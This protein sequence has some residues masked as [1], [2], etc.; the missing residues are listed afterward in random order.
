MTQ[1][2]SV[3]QL[4]FAYERE[5]ILD[6]NEFE[7]SSNSVTAITGA[8]GSGKTTLLN[9]FAL[10]RLPTSGSL[11]FR[12]QVVTKQ[13]LTA[14]RQDIGYVQQKPY[15]L[16]RSVYENVELGLKFRGI[17]ASE[18]AQTV[19]AIL[20]KTD[21]MQLAD[22]HA[23]TL[24]GGESQKV[25][26]ARALV[27]QPS[28]LIL[29][30][31]FS[32]LDRRAVQF[33]EKFIHSL[34]HSIGVTIIFSSHDPIAAQLLSDNVY[35]VVHGRLI[36]S[37]MTNL[38]FGHVDANNRLFKTEKIQIHIPEN[39]GVGSHLTIDP[40][41]LVL[42]RNKLDSSM[43]NQFQGSVIAV[44]QQRSQIRLT[45]NAGE[46]FD[47]LITADAMQDMDIRFGDPVWISFKSSAVRV[48]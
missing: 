13:N 11:S 20:Q 34:R 46:K 47:V 14:L 23:H 17:P 42:S 40:N 21:I 48:F 6:V 18:R 35:S 44:N 12:S 30:E 43:R 36:A 25:A 45:I 41:H 8:N 37:T 33:F 5:N 19:R 7:I 24:S 2:Y 28:V 1:L 3:K 4:S 15:L 10:L 39:A 29:D 9:L 16:N 26:I 27:L 22:R 31:P 38:F 32:H